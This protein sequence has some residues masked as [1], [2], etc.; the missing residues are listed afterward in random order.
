MAVPPHPLP[1]CPADVRGRVWYMSFQNLYY[2]QKLVLGN[3]YIVYFL[4]MAFC[5]SYCCSVF[6]NV[7]FR[8]LWAPSMS[9][10]PEPP[11][12]L[13]FWM[14]HHKLSWSDTADSGHILRA[15]GRT[16]SVSDTR[17]GRRTRTGSRKRRGE[18]CHPRRPRAVG[19]GTA[20]WGL[21]A[22]S[23]P[24]PSVC[25]GLRGGGRLPGWEAS[26]G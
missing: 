18:S 25:P 8:V 7:L 26:V 1:T 9:V 24:H 16:P 12:P 10:D 6:L 20:D 19:L 22:T 17:G 23:L 3:M 13:P 15:K 14:N 5:S 11:S 2:A 4:Q 21:T